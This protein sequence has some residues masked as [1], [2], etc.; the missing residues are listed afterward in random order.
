MPKRR[1]EARATKAETA[2]STHIAPGA[3][4]LSHEAGDNDPLAG[5]PEVECPVEGESIICAD[6]A[7]ANEAKR[8]PSAAVTHTQVG[9]LI[10]ASPLCP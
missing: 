4:G 2:H 9:R 7:M 10:E 1:N 8:M 6:P 5:S 3:K